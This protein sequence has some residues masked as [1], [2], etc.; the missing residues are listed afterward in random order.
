[1][2]LTDLIKESSGEIFTPEERIAQT[3][4][5]I[6][7]AFGVPAGDVGVVQMLDGQPALLVDYS[8]EH[9]LTWARDGRG[10]VI[11]TLDGKRTVSGIGGDR[12]AASLKAAIDALAS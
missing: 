4:K 8:G 9:Y 12:A 6:E 11:W 10:R 5:L 2:A 3:E 1:M 7:R